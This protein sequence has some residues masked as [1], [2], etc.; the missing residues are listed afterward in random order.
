MRMQ[1]GILLLIDP[2]GLSSQERIGEGIWSLESDMLGVLILYHWLYGEGNDL[3]L[4][5]TLPLTDRNYTI[6]D[7][8]MD[9]KGNP[10]GGV[11]PLKDQIKDIVFPYGESLG[12]GE[13][14]Q[15]DITTSIIIENG[16]DIIGYQYLHGT[17][18]EVGGF[19]IQ[20]TISKDAKGDTI[21]DLTYIWNDLIDPNFMY[22]S[23]SPKAEFAKSI[24]G[25]NPTDYY[26]RI[27]W[28]DK[29]II[30]NN[31]GKWINKNK[32]WLSK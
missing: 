9:N 22:E 23:D 11:K 16:E 8:M 28:N 30:R 27:S 17:N 25:A 21:Y 13:S 1:V 20:G 18:E 3:I 19:Q 26:I 7:Y 14:T 4:N 10:S 5:G 6:G 15:I 31:S 2:T 12:M 32:G 29:S 24:P